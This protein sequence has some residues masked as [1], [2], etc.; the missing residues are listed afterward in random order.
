[1]DFSLNLGALEEG[2][3]RKIDEN[4]LYDVIVVEERRMKL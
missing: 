3:L 1:M 4:E 2:K